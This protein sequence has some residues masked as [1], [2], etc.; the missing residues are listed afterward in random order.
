[1]ITRILKQLWFLIW[2]NIDYLPKPIIFRWQEYRLRELL[3]HNFTN[4]LF[5]KGVLLNNNIGF[6]DILK[7]KLQDL[8][9]LPV[10]NKDTFRS[11]GV[12]KCIAKNIPRS[13][14]DIRSTSGSTGEPFRFPFDKKYLRLAGFMYNKIWRDQWLDKKLPRILYIHAIPAKNTYSDRLYLCGLDL[15]E[16]S[17]AE[18]LLK[19]ILDFKAD[20]VE[21]FPSF[22]LELC[23][24]IRGSSTFKKPLFKIAVSCAETLR[25]NDRN[26]IEETLGCKVFNK[27]AVKEFA[28]VGSECEARNGFHLNAESCILEILDDENRILEAGKEGRVVLTNLDNE[29]MPFIHYETGDLGL[30]LKESCQCGNR[31]PLFRIQGRE[32][33]KIFDVGGKKI[34]PFAFYKIFYEQNDYI[35]QYQ[36]VKKSFDSIIIRLVTTPLFKMNAL[37]IFEDRIR[38]ML[39]SDIV[40][41]TFN[42]REKIIPGPSGKK[43]DFVDE[44]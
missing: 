43:A 39:L 31:A 16:D 30:I 14:F 13:R 44:S 40:N 21:S 29:I 18:D 42:I 9:R 11:R 10:I 26:F 5:Y 2:K 32:T 28:C 19:R 34:N 6:K 4:N 33:Q 38:E 17:K 35:R 8:S 36:I 22:Y 12:E 7:F 41:I 23:R 37:S 27:Y 24:R 3:K 20:T 1:M 15:Y 25:D